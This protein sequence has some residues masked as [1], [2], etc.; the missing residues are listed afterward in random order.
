MAFPVFMR[1]NMLGTAIIR[2]FPAPL[3]RMS[4]PVDPLLGYSRLNATVA[5]EGLELSTHS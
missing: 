3:R 2:P 5:R 1:S 4:I